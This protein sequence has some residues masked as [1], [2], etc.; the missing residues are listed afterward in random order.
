M[1]LD[2]FLMSHEDILQK[3]DISRSYLQNL[4]K[5]SH[6]FLGSKAISQPSLK[7]K[8]DELFKL[9]IPKAV[10]ALPEPKNIPLEI[11]FEDSQV[12]V[13]NKPVGL[14]VHPAAG[15]YDDTLVN[16]LLYHC[17]DSL[18]SIGGV[19]RPGIVHRLDKDTSGVM[20]V[21]KT[22]KA[23]HH[24]SEQF[25]CHSITRRY[26]AI[27]YLSP[28]TKTGTITGNIGRSPHNRQKM[29]IV[30]NG[31]KHAVTHFTVLKQALYKNK[32]FASMIEFSLET[33]RTHQIRVHASHNGFPLIG[34]PI[35]GTTNPTILKQIPAELSEILKSIPS[36]AL[37][38]KTLGFIHPINNEYM[39]FHSDYNILFNNIVEKIFKI[40]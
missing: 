29:A 25:A 36:Q 26:H 24:L 37:H 33:G 23:H 38:A 1:R 31:G 20:V 16:A 30:Q 28:K 19:Q 6:L 9:Y 3:H 18:S 7:L 13:I 4:I 8:G 35:Y 12:I 32:I 10:S 14:T 11:L 15:H 39:E 27:A 17:K 40:V 22:D 2:K 34:D 5:D 21:A